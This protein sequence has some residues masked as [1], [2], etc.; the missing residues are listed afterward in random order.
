MNKLAQ[1]ILSFKF[2]LLYS[3]RK[4]EFRN[5]SLDLLVRTS[6]LLA[7]LVTTYPVGVNLIHKFNLLKSFSIAIV[8][9]YGRKPKC[10]HLIFRIAAVKNNKRN[11]LLSLLY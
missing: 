2:F 4:P 8:V 5:Y 1:F 7:Y 10:L 3:T 9:F 6:F 11:T